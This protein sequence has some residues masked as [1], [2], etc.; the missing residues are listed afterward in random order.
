M[1][2]SLFYER[3]IDNEYIL[4]H[5][6]DVYIFK[7]ELEY[8]CDK[9]YDYIGAPWLVNMVGWLPKYNKVVKR[10][11]KMLRLK[12]LNKTGNGGLSLR[13]TNA[14]IKNLKL[15]KNQRNKWKANEDSF[16]SHCVGL[17]NPFFKIAPLNESIKFAFDAAPHLAYRKNNN[18]LPFGCHAWHRNDESYFGVRDFWSKHIDIP[19]YKTPEKLQS[20]NSP[21]VNF[22]AINL[23]NNYKEMNNQN[24]LFSIIIPTYNCSATLLKALK[25]IFR[26]SFT[27]YEILIIDGGSTD[28]TVSI[29][30]ALES[31]KIN[32]FSEKDNGPYDAMNKGI[33]HA[34]GEWLY[35]LGSD[36][37]LYAK[38]TLK[39][40]AKY[41][42]SYICDILY[43]YAR[44]KN[45]KYNYG[46]LWSLDRLLMFGNICHQAIF[47]NKRVF[48]IVG[49]YNVRY[50]IW[51]DWEFNIRCFKNRNICSVFIHTIIAQYND[52]AG[53]SQSHDPV[54]IHELHSENYTVK[55]VNRLIKE[56]GDEKNIFSKNNYVTN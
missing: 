45:A 39:D 5:Q 37:Y 44:F 47:Y 2:S 4:I 24:P 9:N 25:S 32:I 31:D 16:F 42:T 40:I 13:K 3:F 15:F 53:I 56:L 19:F 46:G 43:G 22:P 20:T 10:L 6:T 7:D 35:F 52:G 51:A 11:H 12:A 55:E 34:K 21:T 41:A 36:D 33:K 27:D 54:F 28:G 48:E 17:L 8:W 26:Q 30:E 38:D 23:H 1:L 14:F 50:P 18:Q 49:N 29:A